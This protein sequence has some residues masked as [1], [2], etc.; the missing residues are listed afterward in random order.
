VEFV[1]LAFQGYG[2][3]FVFFS[4]LFLLLLAGR[5]KCWRS[6]LG[7]WRVLCLFWRFWPAVFKISSS[8][9]VPDLHS[10][11]G[12]SKTRA[13]Q[14]SSPSSSAPAAGSSGHGGSRL[15][16][17]GWHA[18][19][20]LSLFGA[21]VGHSPPFLAVH[22]VGWGLRWS[23]LCWVV[24]GRRVS[25]TRRRLRRIPPLSSAGCCFGFFCF[26]V[27]IPMCLLLIT[28]CLYVMHKYSWA[29]VVSARLGQSSYVDCLGFICKEVI[30]LGSL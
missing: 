10:S 15:P 3:L 5:L 12:F 14:R 2:S 29:Y 9:L 6:S 18:P 8:S 22:G 30:Y 13:P 1:P 20:S 11:G 26:S 4:F 17:R 24:P 16:A 7:L 23:I 19:E 21:R 25:S 27:Y 28:V